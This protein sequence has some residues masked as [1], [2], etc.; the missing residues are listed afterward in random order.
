MENHD[1]F[2][3]FNLYAHV[4]LGV[5]RTFIRNKQF[6]R[7]P[8]QKNLRTMHRSCGRAW[9]STRW[10][11]CENCV[12]F[13]FMSAKQPRHFVNDCFHSLDCGVCYLDY[14]CV[15]DVYNWN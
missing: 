9:K 2:F 11:V 7:I 1:I 6:K 4:T 12:T 14:V 13:M 5:L 3:I 10:I 15:Y 8:I